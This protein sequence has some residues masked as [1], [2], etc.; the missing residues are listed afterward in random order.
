M[1]SSKTQEGKLTLWS[2]LREM[3]G[4][5]YPQPQDQAEAAHAPEIIARDDHLSHRTAKKHVRGN[6]GNC[7]FA[8][9]PY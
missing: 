5:V 7:T 9:F 4:T 3:H 6:V 2:W 1:Y 8:S